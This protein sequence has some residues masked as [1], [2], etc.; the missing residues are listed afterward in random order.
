[1]R[2]TID[3]NGR[4]I[5][6]LKMIEELI[7]DAKTRK[8]ALKMSSEKCCPQKNDVVGKSGVTTYWVA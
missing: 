7:S 5:G 3:K 8:M 1:M 4:R 2:Y 6:L